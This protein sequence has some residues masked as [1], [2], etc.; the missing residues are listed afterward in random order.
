LAHAARDLALQGRREP[1][2]RV[3]TRRAAVREHALSRRYRDVERV[4][5]H[6]AQPA[7]ERQ[8]PAVSW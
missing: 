6:T 4:L 2:T 1:L 7:T 8:V 5:A 3:W